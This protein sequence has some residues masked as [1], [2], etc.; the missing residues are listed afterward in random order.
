MIVVTKFGGSSVSSY[1][2]FK[3]VKEIVLKDD[4][5]KVVV[6]SA[7]GK[8]D[9]SDNKIT[10][11]LYL[12]S[13]HVKYKVNYDQVFNTIKVRFYTIKKELNLKIDLEKEFAEIEKNIN[14][15]DYLVS[16]GEYL[17]SLMLSEYLGFKFIDAKDIIEFNYDGKVNYEKTYKLI[18]EKYNKIDKI[19]V[20]GFYGSYP[21]GDI[22]LFSR[23]GSDITGSILARAINATRYENFTDVD[24]FYCASPKIVDNP[25]LISKITYDELRELSY[26][27]A[28][29]IHEETILPIQDL[30]IPLYIKNTF[31]PDGIGTIITKDETESN[32]IITGIA[33]KK[34]FLAINITKSKSQ[35]KLEII[36][37]VLNVLK[38]YHVPIESIPTSIDSFSIVVEENLVKRN[39]YDIVQDLKENE[40]I[41]DIKID[42]G[43]ALI[44]VVGRNMVYKPGISAKLF[45]LLGENKINIK[46]ISQNTSEISI[47]IGVQN[48]DFEKAIKAIYNG[49]VKE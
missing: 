42:D 28:S 5:R 15:E 33:G 49:T 38:K 2:R 43:L 47:I 35:G 16:R 40:D 30:N 22:K 41:I 20:P 1:E 24:G 21:N 44:A 37:Y 29:V 8:I 3:Q 25:R 4:N 17:T 11:L 34:D 18:N 19:V 45:S 14:S 9:S 46:L 48:K 27:G 13:A 31:N 10:D 23:G 7:I 36:D 32:N 6:S 39:I 26:M 12:L